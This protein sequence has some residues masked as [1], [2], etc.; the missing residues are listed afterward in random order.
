MTVESV[1]A[2]PGPFAAD[3][4]IALPVFGQR[5]TEMILREAVAAT[6]RSETTGQ[7]RERRCV[8]RIGHTGSTLSQVKKARRDSVCG[9][10][11]P[12]HGYRAV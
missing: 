10:D 6:S 8:Q 3:G 2:K 5:E 12:V 4:A 9:S 1:V 11:P 7:G